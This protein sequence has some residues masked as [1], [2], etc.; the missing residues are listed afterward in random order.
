MN[1]RRTV[2][3]MPVKSEAYEVDP[4][5]MQTQPFSDSDDSETTR[6]L[7]VV[8]HLYATLSLFQHGS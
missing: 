3:C 8:F 5:A 1:V 6:E 7:C 4:S 2:E